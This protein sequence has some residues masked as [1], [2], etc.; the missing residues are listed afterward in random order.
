M[1]P[2]T[3]VWLAASTWI[4]CANADT[5]RLTRSAAGP[6]LAES[7]K[8]NR[9]DV[10][11]ARRTGTPGGT[12]AYASRSRATAASCAASFAGGSAEI[13]V[14]CSS[15]LPS[16]HLARPC[17]AIMT[18]MRT[19]VQ[20][21]QAPRPPGQTAQAVYRVIRS[22]LRAVSPAW[23]HSRLSRHGSLGRFGVRRRLLGVV[24]GGHLV[25]AHGQPGHRRRGARVERPAQQP[26]HGVA[27]VV[28][29]RTVEGDVGERA[30]ACLPG[31]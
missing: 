16:G 14:T 28:G 30:V 13:P 3:A 11:L 5:S 12:A 8:R 9:L 2:T 21:G 10:G 23:T 27:T 4:T 25:R 31:H 24:A 26:G 18:R 6:G 19:G 29:Q 17:A 7:R 20:T 22:Q 1:P 15:S